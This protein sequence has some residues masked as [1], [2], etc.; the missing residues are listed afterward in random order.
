MTVAKNR[1]KGLSTLGWLVAIMVGG[2]MIMLALR[3]APIYLDDYAIKKVLTSLDARPGIEEADVDQVR[4]WLNKGLLTNRVQLARE[5]S[6]VLRDKGQS[7]AVEINYERRVHL[8]HNA[9][10]VLTFEHN[11]NAKTQ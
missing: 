11:W 9:D 7:V 4:E 5:E 10:L 2:F 1:Q 3:V 8:I 6:S